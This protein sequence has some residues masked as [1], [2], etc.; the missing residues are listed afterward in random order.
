M[1]A[2]RLAGISLLAGSLCNVEQLPEIP[3]PEWGVAR[4]DPLGCFPVIRSPMRRR[5]PL[6]AVQKICSHVLAL[7]SYIKV[8][9]RA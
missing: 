9:T 4:F 2:E 8:N 1:V 5:D 6:A 3:G 7:S